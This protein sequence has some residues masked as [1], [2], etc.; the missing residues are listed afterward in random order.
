MAAAAG[1]A[2]LQTPTVNRTG[3]EHVAAVVRFDKDQIATLKFFSYQIRYMSEVS[4]RRHPH[5]TAFRH[6]PEIIYCIVRHG[7]RLEIDIADTEIAAGFYLD[8]A[9]FHRIAAFRAFVRAIAVRRT[10][11]A[12]IRFLGLA[13]NVNAAVDLI[14]KI[15]QAADVIGVLMRNDYAVKAR[16]SD[17]DLGKATANLA[18]AQAGVHQNPRFFTCDQHGVAGRAGA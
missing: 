6:K 18:R 11:P 14:Q 10:V 7:E 13:R 9:G 17:A 15:S 16:R 4:Q 3:A 2:L 12:V 8:A 1:D 5:A